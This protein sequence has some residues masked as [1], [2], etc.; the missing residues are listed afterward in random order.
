MGRAGPGRRPRRGSRGGR[1]EHRPVPG[2]HGLARAHRRGELPA[3][4]SGGSGAPR[5]GPRSPARRGRSHPDC[6]GRPAGPGGARL[7]RSA[8]PCPPACLQRP[9][10]R[11]R[12]RAGRRLP[13]TDGGRTSWSDQDGRSWVLDPV[14]LLCNLGCGAA[15]P[16]AQFPHLSQEGVGPASLICVWRWSRVRKA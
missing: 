12:R 14:P 4:L 10:G 3:A 11:R 13:G 6:A 9:H 2:T 1:T 5:A 7:S 15:L 8:A 16:G